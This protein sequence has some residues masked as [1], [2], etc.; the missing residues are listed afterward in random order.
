MGLKANKKQI[1]FICN[2]NVTQGPIVSFSRNGWKIYSIYITY[3]TVN[4]VTEGVKTFAMI[5]H[6]L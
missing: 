2:R 3:T 1:L 4:K 5:E 6:F